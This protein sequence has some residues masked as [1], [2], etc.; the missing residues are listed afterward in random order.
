LA[1]IEAGAS[2]RY[3]AEVCAVAVRLFREQ[4]FAFSE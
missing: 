4:G 1:E 3:D 2:T